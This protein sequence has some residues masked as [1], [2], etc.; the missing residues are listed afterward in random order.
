[1]RGPGGRGAPAVQVSRGR[2]PLGPS[3]PLAGRRGG[4][5]WEHGVGGEPVR[6]P[7]RAPAAPERGQ[8]LPGE[9]SSPRAARGGGAGQR[10]EPGGA[11]GGEPARFSR[12]APA[13]SS[14]AP[15]AE[16]G[17]VCPSPGAAVSGGSPGPDRLARAQADGGCRAV[18]CLCAQACPSAP[19]P[20]DLGLAQWAALGRGPM[21]RRRPNRVGEGPRCRPPLGRRASPEAD[22][23]AGTWLSVAPQAALGAKQLRPAPC[24][25]CG[26]YGQSSA[27]GG[28][29]RLQACWR[30]AR[31][32][33]RAITG[34]ILRTASGER[35]QA[36]DRAVSGHGTGWDSCWRRSPA[37]R[38]R[39]APMPWRCAHLHEQAQA[40][41]RA[42]EAGAR[43][44][45]SRAR[46]HAA[47]GC[48]RGTGLPGHRAARATAPMPQP[49]RAAGHP[50]GRRGLTRPGGPPGPLYGV[51]AERA[52]PPERLAPGPASRPGPGSRSTLAIPLTTESRDRVLPGRD[53]RAR[54]RG[55]APGGPAE[56]ERLRRATRAR[57]RRAARDTRL[58]RSGTA[59]SRRH[60]PVTPAGR[61]RGAPLVRAATIA[62][63]RRMCRVDA[64]QRVPGPSHL[65]ACHARPVLFP[66]AARP[67]HVPR[68]L[69]ARCGGRRGALPGS[70]PASGLRR[71]GAQGASQRLPLSSHEG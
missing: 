29:R 34:P 61:Q 47:T 55:G 68:A 22:D 49:W 63:E 56:A 41:P 4:G 27:P 11:C 18:G 17:G 39:A 71:H 25:R 21:R 42:L 10:T 60:R 54:L 32:G 67:A 9:G 31:G 44:G 52:L 65:G 24:R 16:R 8:A 50:A 6:D 2:L 3:P 43:W 7:R 15:G 35:P 70:A 12:V 48:G 30:A 33:R 23:E 40:L 38:W 69:L 58:T 19:P 28:R 51:Q 53:K 20:A 57:V 66:A 1:V 64:L 37:L 36:K 5:C 13:G 14:R 26:P 59:A 46:R 62:D 45:N